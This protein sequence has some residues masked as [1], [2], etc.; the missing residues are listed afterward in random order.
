VIR[1]AALA[2]ERRSTV[3][4]RAGRGLGEVE[5]ALVGSTTYQVLHL[6]AVPVTLVPRGGS[7]RANR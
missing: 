4:M 1:P 5:S 3:P 7:L 6:A 2:A